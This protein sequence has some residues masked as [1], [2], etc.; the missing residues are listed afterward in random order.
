MKKWLLLLAMVVIGACTPQED[1]VANIPTSTFLPIPSQQP[2]YTATP[3]STRTP[4]P[5]FTYTPTNTPIP[6]TITRTPVPTATPTVS[7]IVQSLQR[8]NIRTGPGEDFNFF[9]SLAPG[10][11]VQVIGQTAEGDW[12]NVR[13]EDGREG[14]VSA[15]LLFIP[16]TATPFASTG[17]TPDMTALFSAQPLPTSILGGGTITPTTV[18]LIVTATKVGLPT[19][20]PEGTL[21]PTQPF[22]P[23]VS[24]V[25]SVN[26]STINSTATAL[27]QGAATSTPSR[28]PQA[29]STEARI[30]TIVPDGTTS[31]VTTPIVNATAAVLGGG[32][33]DNRANPNVFAF[34][35]NVSAFGIS[36]PTTLTSG[37]TIDIWWNWYAK[38]EDQV[39]EHLDHSLIDLK[40]N[41]QAIANVN[42]YASPIRKSGSDFVSSWYI[43]Y[44]PLAAG[45]YEITYVVTWDKTIFDGYEYFGPDSS[46]P[47]E[48]ETCTFTVR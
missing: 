14:W 20:T 40:V 28:T 3:E 24:V 9:D 4:L 41:G 5:T 48:Q 37:A 43:S 36:A 30:L 33:E 25:P 47:F 38:Q 7:G 31:S 21:T 32:G 11:G 29:N 46:Q 10:T 12:F 45:N 44:G 17:A 39:Q 6:P 1:V 42:S 13:L 23:I 22:V 34:C 15:R 19:S 2:R 26:L 8:V 35:D 27:A 18:S 16:A